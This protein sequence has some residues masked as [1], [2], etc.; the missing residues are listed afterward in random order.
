[1][2]SPRHVRGARLVVGGVVLLVVVTLLSSLTRY[3]L[4]AWLH[5]HIATVLFR[6]FAGHLAVLAAYPVVEAL[7]RLGGSLYLVL[8]VVQFMGRVRARYP[9]WHRVSGY[10][11]L[12]LTL[13]IGV[14]GMWIGVVLP[15]Q[16]GESVPSLLFGALMLICA[17]KALVCARRRE[18]RAHREWMIRSFSIGLGV[19]AIRV[20]GIPLMAARVGTAADLIVAIFWLGFVSTLLVAELWIRASRVTSG[21]RA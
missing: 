2:G 17:G 7:H 21:G 19:G 8:G 6:D 5:M 1:M 3:V 18:L 20:F 11:F 16:P 14:S 9:G 13:L 4:P 15:Y 12:G 10:V